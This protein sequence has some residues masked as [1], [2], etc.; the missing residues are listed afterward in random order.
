MIGWGRGVAAGRLV[1]LLTE[2]RVVFD[3]PVPRW[4]EVGTDAPL[5]GRV[6]APY[7]EAE[8]HATGPGGQVQTLHQGRDAAFAARLRCGAPGVHQIE[9]L[10]RDPAGPRVLANF[11]I[12][13]ADA[14]PSAWIAPAWADGSTI[15]PRAAERALWA[16]VNADRAGAG[17]HA[18]IW[19][20][21]LAAVARAHSMDMR[22]HDFVAHVSPRTGDVGDRVARAGVPADVVMENIGAADTAESIHAGLMQSPAH[23]AAVLAPEAN[24]GGVGVTVAERAHTAH[25]LLATEVFV[26]D[27]PSFLPGEAAARVRDAYAAR[28]AEAGRALRAEAAL[29]DVAHGLARDLA[30]DRLLPEAASQVALQRVGSAGVDLRGVLLLVG[31]GTDPA[32]LASSPEA[33]PPEAVSYGV[34]AATRDGRHLTVLLV[35]LR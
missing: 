5:R 12:Y 3:E 6:L 13:C 4:L 19:D 2:R 16:R 1:I 35:G 24:R 17:L 25:T 21:R 10:G 15:E 11:P 9:V 34:G 22:D 29:D 23:R 28:A 7:G 14:P 30:A 8:V 33:L 27:P 18:L 31:Q 32:R 20:D 26:S